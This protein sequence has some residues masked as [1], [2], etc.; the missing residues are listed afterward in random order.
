MDAIVL[1]GGFGTRLQHIVTDVPKPMAPVCGR[2]FLEYVLSHLKQHGITRV[3]L[4]VGYKQ[5]VIRSYFGDRYIDM[6]LIYSSEDTP[7]FTGGAIKKALTFCGSD[8]V[9]VV[10]G[11]TYFDVDLKEML[12][13]HCQKNAQLTIAAK[14][15]TNFNRYGALKIDQGRITAFLEKQETSE[16]FING[17]IYLINPT[18][19][20]DISQQSFSF[21]KEVMEKGVDTLNMYSFLSDGYFVDIGIPEDYYHAQVDFASKGGMYE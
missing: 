1:A 8:P 13:F 15:M 7:L 4:A 19:L 5:E 16:G 17:G 6:E 20:T 14:K 21:E 11:D 9:F 3:V 18:L 10:N 12:L 2:P